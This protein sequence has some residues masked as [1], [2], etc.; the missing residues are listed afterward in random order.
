MYT[1]ARTF[2]LA[3]RM[4]FLIQI[5]LLVLPIL[6]AGENA[7]FGQGKKAGLSFNPDIAFDHLGENAGLSSNYITCMLTDREGFLWIGTF[8]GLNRY[9][10]KRFEI[11]RRDKNDPSSILQNVITSLATDSKGNIWCGTEDGITMYDKLSKKFSHF[12]YDDTSMYPRANF[13]TVDDKDNLWAGSDNGLVRLDVKKRKFTYFRHDTLNTSSLPHNNLSKNSLVFDPLK[14]GMWVGTNKGLCFMQISDGTFRSHRNQK[15]TG[16]FN[17][18]WISALHLSSSGILWFFDNQT[19]EIIGID[20]KLETKKY[21]IPLKGVLQDP[22]GGYIF[23]T[24]DNR[25][26]FSSN[27][28][29]IVQLDY[30][31]GNK[32]TIIKHDESNPTSIAGDYASSIIEDKDRT[33]WLGTVAGISR[34]N[35]QRLFYRII[36]TS[37]TFPEVDENWYITTVAQDPVTEHYWLGTREDKIYI[38]QPETDT[39]Q[40]LDL[41]RYPKDK[42]CRF[43]TDLEFIDDLV[44][45][46]YAGA[47]TYQYHK[48]QKSFLPFHGLTKKYS[49]YK[50]R[51]M[52]QESDSTYIIGNDLPLLRWN[53]RTNTIRELS[54]DKTKNNRGIAYGAGWLC[55]KKDKGSWIS[56]SNEDVAF[57]KPGANTLITKSLPIGTNVHQGGYFHAMSVDDYG[58][59]WIPFATQGLFHLR[60]KKNDIGKESDFELKQWTSADGL[61]N[62]IILTAVPDQRGNIWCASQHHFSVFNPTKN[63]FV[64]FKIPLRENNTFYY[65]Y[66]IP[67]KNG[68]ILTNIGGDLVECNP[69]LFKDLRPKNAVQ[70]SSL[71][72]PGR[73]ILLDNETNVVLEP[74]ENFITLGFGSISVQQYMNYAYE[75]K[76]EGVNETWIVSDQDGEAVYTDLA[77][78]HY[79]FQVRT[80]SRDGKWKNEASTLYI[81][82]KAPFYKTWWFLSVI[83]LCLACLVYYFVT[84]RLRNIQNINMLKTKTQLLEKEKTTVMYENLKQHL[85]PHFLFNSLTSLSSLIRLDP[86]KALDFLDKMSKV[87]RYILR[88]KDNETVPLAEEINF[89]NMYI[90]LQKTRFEDGLNIR[91]DISDEHLHR[92]IVPVTLQNLIENAI[93]HNTADPESPL[94]IELFIEDDYLIVRNN[95]QKKNFVETSNKQGQQSMVS[96]YRF[97]SPSPLVIDETGGYYTVRIP[98]I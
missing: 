77:P 53:K 74:H 8:N 68:H 15:N 65:N 60:K 86:K 2:Y 54:F 90:Q 98:L 91:Q 59:V 16:I 22:Y 14:G 18:H 72:V 19:K 78:G 94:V 95:L 63:S 93:K 87:Y 34:Y 49:Q 26:W 66:M 28:Y 7:I 35:P 41:T 96:L 69:D 57:L 17:N 80:I 13:I 20:P 97:L 79:T 5:G 4:K 11:F 81:R 55:G 1:S 23:E 31:N 29:E 75:Y 67:L 44:V 92:R 24:S 46:C 9:D 89:V 39:W 10:G 33:L 45:V 71:K 62:E 58:Q 84:A 64:N 47:P 83:F 25:L 38:Y 70:I 51:V 52:V 36:K 32:A 42:K 76:L 6:F 30:K 82:I 50:A 43:I 21:V 12:M 48:R 61:V 73:K 27:S 37:K 40:K 3:S 56:V 85:N 88:N